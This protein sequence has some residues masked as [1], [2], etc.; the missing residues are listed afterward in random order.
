VPQA[1]SVGEENEVA[2]IERLGPVGRE[3]AS[4]EPWS[5]ADHGRYLQEIG[6]GHRH[7][8]RN[9]GHASGERRSVR[10][11]A[12]RI[13]A[14]DFEPLPFDDDFGVVVFDDC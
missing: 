13:I 9:G 5:D 10:R 1:D 8:P 2:Y 7:R 3:H 12:R 4:N 6:C 14:T 11:A